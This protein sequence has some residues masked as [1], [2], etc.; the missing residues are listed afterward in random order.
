MRLSFLFQHNLLCRVKTASAN[1]TFLQPTGEEHTD[2]TRG[3]K[4]LRRPKNMQEIIN[5][6]ACFSTSLSS[7]I[8]SQF[9]LD[10]SVFWFMADYCFDWEDIQTSVWGPL[11]T[12]ICAYV[13]NCSCSTEG[14]GCLCHGRFARSLI[15]SNSFCW[16]KILPSRNRD[17]LKSQ[18]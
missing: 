13:E 1:S 6:P 16:L 12:Q 4:L 17:P 7:F 2:L 10:F 5:F 3:G 9:L 14:S 15:V 18:T 11:W 8:F